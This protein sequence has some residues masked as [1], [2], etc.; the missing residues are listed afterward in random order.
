MFN[1]FVNLNNVH[2]RKNVVNRKKQ[3]YC[4]I[5]RNLNI[6]EIYVQWLKS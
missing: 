1:I 2:L 4:A 5:E 3:E 6:N